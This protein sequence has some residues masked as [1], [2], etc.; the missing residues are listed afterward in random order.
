MACGA[1][2][3][4]T[5]QGDYTSGQQDGARLGTLAL[6]PCEAEGGACEP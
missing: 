3:G 1:Q 4:W 2:G 6:V 5:G